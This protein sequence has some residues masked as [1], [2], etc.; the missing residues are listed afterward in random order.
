[1]CGLWFSLF[2][3]DFFFQLFSQVLPLLEFLLLLSRYLLERERRFYHEDKQH[4]R[5]SVDTLY[6]GSDQSFISLV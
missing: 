6:T 2:F 3:N 1:M 5:H 4:S